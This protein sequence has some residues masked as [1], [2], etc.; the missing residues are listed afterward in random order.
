M[1]YIWWW[2]AAVGFAAAWLILDAQPTAARIWGALMLVPIPVLVARQTAMAPDAATL[3]RRQ[4][5]TSTIVGLWIL[6][7]ITAVA[8]RWGNIDAPRLG[9]VVPP[10]GPLVIWSVGLTAAGVV[11]V[12]VSRALGV[13][14]SDMTRR[15]LPGT[16]AERMAFAALSLTAGFCEELIFRGFLLHLMHG[17]TGSMIVAV[18]VTSAIFGWMH[19]YQQPGGAIRAAFLGALLA[20]PPALAGSIVASMIAHAALDII[21][22]IF[23]RDRLV[24][25]VA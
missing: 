13:R 21:A 9:L 5:Y 24:P 10:L 22:G 2:V 7:G 23:L 1:R 16:L 14:E 4:L 19:A 25:D 6:A 15:M 8:S 20:L 18:G 12:Y 11:V 17:A 3:P